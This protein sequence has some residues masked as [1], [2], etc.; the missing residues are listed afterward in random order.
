MNGNR[1][2]VKTRF[3]IRVHALVCLRMEYRKLIVT[4]L[5]RRKLMTEACSLINWPAR[6][7][8][9]ERVTASRQNETRARSQPVALKTFFQSLVKLFNMPSNIYN[10][11]RA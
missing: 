4:L 6:S 8:I 10:V 1:E 11:T 3:E 9:F 2:K 5:L 7:A